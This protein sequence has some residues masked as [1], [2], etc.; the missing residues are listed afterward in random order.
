MNCSKKDILQIKDGKITM[1]R[2]VHNEIRR[3]ADLLG[4]FRER[5]MQTQKKLRMF[6]KQKVFY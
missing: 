5:H 3:K 6:F 4:L 2:E 1:F